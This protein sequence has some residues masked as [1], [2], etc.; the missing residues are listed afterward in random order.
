MATPAP[1][2]KPPLGR[3]DTWVDEALAPFRFFVETMSL[4]SVAAMPGSD[5]VPSFWVE[6]LELELPFEMDV[7]IES[8]ERVRL[9]GGPPTQYTETTFMPVFHKIRLCVTGQLDSSGTSPQ[10]GSG[11]KLVAGT[12]EPQLAS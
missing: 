10:P 4:A 12:A 9:A 1:E 7:R 3:D 2:N 8:H 5:H 11:E 6:Q